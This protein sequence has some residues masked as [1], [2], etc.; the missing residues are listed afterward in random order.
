MKYIL[1][2]LL[3]STVVN[4]REM[5]ITGVVESSKTQ[6]VLMPLVRSF[7]GKISDM[8]E[9]G[10]FVEPGDVL[11][12]VDGAEVYSTIESQQESLDVFRATSKRDLINLKIEKNNA[13]V[14]HEKAKVDKKVAQVRAQVPVNF[15]GELEY[16]ERQLALKQSDKALNQAQA[17]LA[18]VVRKEQEKEQEIKLGLEQKNSKLDYWKERL[19]SFSVKAQQSGYVIYGTQNWTGRKIQTGDQV[20]S[21]SEVLKVSQNGNMKII[22]WINAIDIP[23]IQLDNAVTVAFDALPGVKTTGSIEE[24]SA[25]GE[26]KQ[27][28]GSG[29]YYK[30]VIALNDTDELP[31]LAGM[32]ALISIQTE[33]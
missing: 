18:E 28:W 16:K 7:N 24:I 27:D 19:E 25:G 33:V 9:E 11:M 8:A 26:D 17:A 10:S 32:S 21:G 5:Y 31:L 6:N 1:C 29:L 4:A 12:Q 2:M 20:Q 3:V 23:A 22:A 14:A 15:I 13:M 30:V